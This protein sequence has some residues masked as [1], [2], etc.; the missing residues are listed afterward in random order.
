MTQ[1]TAKPA[2]DFRWLS[3]HLIILLL[4]IIQL[5]TALAEPV[6]DSSQAVSVAAMKLVG[7]GTDSKAGLDVRA[8]ATL[9]DYVL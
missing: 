5:Q 2:V 6:S 8:V 3:I 7:F 1:N 4:T 9:V